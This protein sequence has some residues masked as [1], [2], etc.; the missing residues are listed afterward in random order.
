MVLSALATHY[1]K[2]SLRLL[3][4]TGLRSKISIEDTENVL[5]Y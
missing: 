4:R 1:I 2:F 5:S 3:Q